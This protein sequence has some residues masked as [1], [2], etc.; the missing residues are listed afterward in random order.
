M[1]I[2]RTI[3][4]LI[5]LTVLFI[6]IRLRR[7]SFK[8]TLAINRPKIKDVFIYV[9]IFIIWLCATELF[10]GH[11]GILETGQ[12]KNY[13]LSH[14]VIRGVSI[15]IVAP[16]S[17]ELIFRGLLFTR[18]RD[19]FGLGAALFLPSALFALLHIKFEEGNTT[20][21]FASVTFID[22]VY[23]SYARYKSN[24]VFVP[25]ILHSL[26]NVVAMIER[27]W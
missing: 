26:G 5:G 12:W 2:Y 20:L 19:R 24:S 7:L 4:F 11:L 3:G 6:V 15:C 8:D 14:I 10:F 17:E 23:Y 18:V 1:I 27:L 13:S 25:I 22:A 21:L 9:C 16:F